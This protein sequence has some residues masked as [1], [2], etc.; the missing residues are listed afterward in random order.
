M[1]A[2]S[3][4]PSTDTAEQIVQQADPQLLKKLQ[5]EQRERVL[6]IV[7]QTITSFEGP[8]P[9]PHMLAEYD[10][11]IPQGADR[12][13]RLLE[14]QTQHRHTQE[15]RIVS[16]QT[17]LPVRGQII[18]T[19]LCVFFGAIG[20][21]LAFTGH[22]WVAGVLFGTTILGLVTIFVLG[23][24]PKQSSPSSS[25]SRSKGKRTK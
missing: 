12:L 25:A 10:R 18:G 7:Q 11:L 2:S 4:D 9:P 13:M 14:P 16:S 6:R 19:C 23:R 17:S 3:P 8:L 22:D 5:P 1:S 15:T 24:V 20:W 21:H